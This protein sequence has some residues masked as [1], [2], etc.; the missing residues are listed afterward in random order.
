MVKTTKEKDVK[1]CVDKINQLK[2][3][4]KPILYI[5]IK[6]ESFDASDIDENE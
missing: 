6:H 4:G 2:K 3:E 1:D 5:E